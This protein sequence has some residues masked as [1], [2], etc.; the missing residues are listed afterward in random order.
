MRFDTRKSRRLKLRRPAA[1]MT[2]FGPAQLV[3]LGPKSVALLSEW[4]AEKGATTWLEFNWGGY[5]MRL[6][7]EVRS[8][9][10]SRGDGR[11]RSGLLICGGF[12][13]DE[14]RN[15]VKNELAKAP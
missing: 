2:S 6:D 5:L 4:S 9:R 8:C 1:A 7:C 11:N 15:R 13:A 14:F 12:S 3:D 10:F